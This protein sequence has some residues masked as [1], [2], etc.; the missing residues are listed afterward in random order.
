MPTCILREFL[1]YQ[2]EEFLFNKDAYN[3]LDENIINFWDMSKG[4]APELS[5]LHYTY[6][7][8]I[9]YKLAGNNKV[10]ELLVVTYL[11]VKK[12]RSFL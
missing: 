6:L 4:L 8:V 11:C 1:A 3:Q 5:Q 7:K 10:L 9:N 2:W 12:A